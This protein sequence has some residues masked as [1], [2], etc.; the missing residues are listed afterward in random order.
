MSIGVTSKAKDAAELTSLHR[1]PANSRAGSENQS[2]VSN[3][4]TVAKSDVFP[5]AINIFN[6]DAEMGLYTLP[7]W[8]VR[9]PQHA[10]IEPAGAQENSF[11]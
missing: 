3:H 4:F 11:R 2:I 1:K 5:D 8:V 7:N 6:G 10:V 9:L